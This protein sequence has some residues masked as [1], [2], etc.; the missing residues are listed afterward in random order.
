[1]PVEHKLLNIP[2]EGF[3]FSGYYTENGILKNDS[4]MRSVNSMFIG[5]FIPKANP[6][7]FFNGGNY[8]WTV[9]KQMESPYHEFSNER[10]MP[11]NAQPDLTLDPSLFWILSKCYLN[12]MTF[13]DLISRVL[14][15]DDPEYTLLDTD[16]VRFNGKEY[17]LTQE[18]ASNGVL[19]LTQLDEQDQVEWNTQN[20]IN[21]LIEN[22]G[23]KSIYLTCRPTGIWGQQWDLITNHESLRDRNFVLLLPPTDEEISKL[24]SP[25]QSNL[26]TLLHYWVWNGQTHKKPVNNPAFGHLDHSWLANC[27]IDVEK[28]R[29]AELMVNLEF[30]LSSGRKVKL[31]GFYFDITYGGLLEGIVDDELNR[32]FFKELSYPR[33]WGNRRSLKIAPTEAE[34]S[35]ILKPYYCAAWLSSH[36]IKEGDS[37]ELVVIWLTERIDLPIVEL[38][39]D[40]VKGFDWAQEAEDGWL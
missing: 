12:G 10:R 36:E 18:D 11:K 34:F 14:H 23:T 13:S 39:Q 20:I 21:F 27:Y 1:M 33:N 32:E 22:A 15:K 3:P 37:S 8:F 9:F 6:A 19:G 17:S 29:K 16:H 28:I 31:D 2:D 30:N 7:D 38:I 35:S 4:M 25:Y 24:P 26:K 40:G 5:P